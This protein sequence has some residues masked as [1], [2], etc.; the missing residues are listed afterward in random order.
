[1]KPAQNGK[2]EKTGLD[3]TDEDEDVLS[4]FDFIPYLA[5]VEYNEEGV[6]FT[7]FDGEGRVKE[8]VDRTAS[9]KFW[10]ASSNLRC[11]LVKVR[12]LR[13]SQIAHLSRPYR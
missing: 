4:S 10:I 13:A 12:N 3:A 8:S 5:S 7:L 11:R 6:M 1:M 2:N 9:S